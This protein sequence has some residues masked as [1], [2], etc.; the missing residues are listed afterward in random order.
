MTPFILKERRK[1]P[2]EKDPLDEYVYDQDRQVWVDPKSGTPAIDCLRA[3]ASASQVG[4]TTLTETREGVDQTEGAV[5]EATPFGETLM[6]RTVEGVD[7][8]EIVGVQASPFGETTVTATLEGIDQTEIAGSLGSD[9]GETVITRSNEGH[10]QTEA[11]AYTGNA[12]A[13]QQP[14]RLATLYATYSHF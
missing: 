13:S 1:L 11:A 12:T 6:T 8:S 5:L 2:S 10:D 4:E 3:R 7:Q 14:P 9:F